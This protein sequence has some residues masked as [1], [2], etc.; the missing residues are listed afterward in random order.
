M[1]LPFMNEGSIDHRSAALVGLTHFKSASAEA[2][3]DPVQQDGAPILNPLS[4]AKLF[5]ASPVLFW[6]ANNDYAQLVAKELDKCSVAQAG[7]QVLADIYIGRGLYLYQEDYS[8]GRKVVEQQLPPE[9]ADAWARANIEEYFDH[10]MRRYLTW[11]NLW[12]L[13]QFSKTR[14]ITGIVSYDS[15]WCRLE[16]PHYNTGAIE[17]IYVSTQWGL[18]NTI[19]LGKNIPKGMLQW[20]RN[21]PLVSNY[22]TINELQ[23]KKYAGNYLIAQHLFN[24]APNRTYGRMPWLAAYENGWVNIS[25][26]QPKMKSAIYDNLIN[27][28]R[29]AY[30][31]NQFFMDTVGGA[32]AFNL[33]NDQEKV[34]KIKAFQDSV[35]KNLTG[36]EKSG[37]TFFTTKNTTQD[38][39]TIKAIEF[40]TIANPLKDLSVLEDSQQADAEILL[41]LMIEPSLLGAVVPG[42]GKQSAGSGS[43]IREALLATS[44]RAYPARQKVLTP[45]YNWLAYAGWDKKYADK[46]KGLGP[47]KI[48]V[49]DFIIGTQDGAPPLPNAG[50]APTN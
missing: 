1:P 42:G 7:L 24:P 40:E 41:A 22:N 13:Y 2:P 50:D 29:V 11:G 47:L 12:P 19:T 37:K 31:D 39:K 32:T 27:L 34:A 25:A 3:A 44:A 33:L 23:K 15:A 18:Y 28:A 49:R 6:G 46:T 4:Y 45:L 17:S 30:I 14:K 21:F 16:R 36:A 20:V 10:G 8:S 48:G 43:N 9:I 35:D 38:G 26:M 5:Q